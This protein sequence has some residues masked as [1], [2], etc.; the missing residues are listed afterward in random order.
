MVA[1]PQLDRLTVQDAVRRHLQQVDR[2]VAGK[3]LAVT[4][5]GNYHRDLAEFAEL[6]GADTVLDDLTAET[7]DDIL[8]TY[9]GRPDGRYTRTVKPSVHAGAPAPGRGP[10]ATARFRQPVSRLFAVAERRGWIALN[11]MPDTT[12]RPK[13]SGLANAARLAPSEETARAMLQ[14]PAVRACQGSR[15]GNARLITR[16]TALLAV[17]FEDG[18]RVS[19]LCSLDRSDLSRRDGTD[20]LHIREGKGGKPRHVPLSPGTAALLRTWLDVPLHPLPATVT[21]LARRDAATAMFTTYRG[22]RIQPRSVQHL[23]TRLAASLPDHLR[24]HI[25]PHAARHTAATLLLSSGAADVRTVQAILGHSSLNTTGIYLDIAS[26]GLARAIA[27]HPL[28]G[29]PPLAG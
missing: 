11:P 6:A 10:G 25:T 19:E 4:T 13:P 21:D 15:A 12:V 14:Q 18:L 9:A 2:A 28:A 5:A 24:R 8:V 16:D 27:A 7:I 23:F 3:G 1:P 29:K 17:L 22:R 26:D 20:W